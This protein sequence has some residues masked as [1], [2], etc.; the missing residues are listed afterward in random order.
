MSDLKACVLATVVVTVIA[1][2]VIFGAFALA[3]LL[4]LFVGQS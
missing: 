4:R 3:E 1:L 2:S